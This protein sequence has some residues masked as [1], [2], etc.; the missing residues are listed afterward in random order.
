MRP[1][2]RLLLS[3]VFEAALQD[4]LKA[5]TSFLHLLWSPLFCSR[6][7]FRAWTSQGEGIYKTFRSVNTV[8]LLFSV[9]FCTFCR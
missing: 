8:F 5:A 4:E 3:L 7:L 6:H 2:Y 1:I 9:C